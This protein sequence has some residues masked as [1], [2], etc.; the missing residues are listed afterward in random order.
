MTENHISKRE[1]FMKSIQLFVSV[2]V[3]SLP[4]YGEEREI[5]RGISHIKLWEKEYITTRVVVNIPYAV[6]I[7]FYK[8]FKIRGRRSLDFWF[9]MMMMMMMMGH[10]HKII[11]SISLK[12]TARTSR[13]RRSKKNVQTHCL[14]EYVRPLVKSTQYSLCLSLFDLLYQF[15]LSVFI[16]SRNKLEITNSI[17][18]LRLKI[19]WW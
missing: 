6:S 11:E 12:S 13:Y 18:S 1:Y 19:L 10:A 15:Q 7:V 4:T 16:G 9:S 14:L 5:K 3:M 17:C 8:L 2:Y